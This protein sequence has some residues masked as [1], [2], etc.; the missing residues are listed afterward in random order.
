MGAWEKKAG[1][2]WRSGVESEHSNTLDN[3]SFELK[4]FAVLHKTLNAERCAVR[5]M[6]A[7]M[8]NYVSTCL[9]VPFGNKRFAEMTIFDFAGLTITRIPGYLKVFFNSPFLLEAHRS[10]YMDLKDKVNRSISSPA[11]VGMRCQGIP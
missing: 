2:K 1:E 9:R 11:F 7:C 3:F 5:A 6:S 10:I 4:R 8:H